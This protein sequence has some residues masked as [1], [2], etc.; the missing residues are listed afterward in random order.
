MNSSSYM[1]PYSMGSFYGQQPF[2]YY[3]G[4][5]RPMMFQNS[6]NYP[7][8]NFGQLALDESRSAFSTIESVIQTFRAIS[9]LLESTFASVYSSFR[10]VTDV[11]DHFS[12][13]RNEIHNIYPLVLLWR[14][15]KFLYHRLLRILRLRESSPI[16]N[17]EN[18]SMIYQQIQESTGRSSSQSNSSSSF[19]VAVFFLVS[20]GTPMLMFKILNSILKKRQG[21]EKKSKFSCFFRST[22]RFSFQPRTIG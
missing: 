20:F 16:G 7:N 4:G 8:G 17:E 21:F 5:Y 10:A 2:G 11:F 15:L 1:S 14:F 9:M 13:V 3:N 12:R 19:L 22:N 6:M 18:W